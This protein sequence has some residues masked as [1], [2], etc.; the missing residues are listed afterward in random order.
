MEFRQVFYV[1]TYGTAAWLGLQA[2]PLILLPKAI[3]TM[4]AEDLHQTTGK[5][6]GDQIGDRRRGGGL[7]TYRPA[8]LTLREMDR[9]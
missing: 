7:S 6:S 8:I 5:A 1:Y 2:L 4:L 9:P 3:T